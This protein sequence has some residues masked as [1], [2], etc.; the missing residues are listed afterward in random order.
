T[1][2]PSATDQTFT[3]PSA[4]PVE[5]WRPSGENTTERALSLWPRSVCSS[6]R[7]PASKRRA[8]PPRAPGAVGLPALRP[9]AGVPGPPRAGQVGPILAGGQ[10]PELDLARVTGP[11]PG[12]RHRDELL[13]IG[14]KGHRPDAELVARQ[15]RL[16]LA[17]LPIPEVDRP[18]H[19]ARRQGLAVGR[20]GH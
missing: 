3:S 15:D 20:D 9:A 12:P 4:L 18:V 7:E 2:L 6:L 11:M 13:A 1:S 8:T 5:R 17:R 14:R 10:V 19:V 16:A